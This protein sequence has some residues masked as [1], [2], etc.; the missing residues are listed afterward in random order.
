VLARSDLLLRKI[1]A[2]MHDASLS[3]L[4]EA[5]VFEAVAGS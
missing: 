4:F 1:A 3:L 5:H 2:A